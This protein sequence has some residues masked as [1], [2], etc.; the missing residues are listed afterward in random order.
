MVILVPAALVY[1]NPVLV[2]QPALL[3]FPTINST[4]PPVLVFKTNTIIMVLG[5]LAALLIVRAALLQ[6]VLSVLVTSL[7]P[8]IPVV[9][10]LDSSNLIPLVCLVSSTAKSVPLKPL[11]V[12]V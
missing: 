10:T 6:N 7:H 5:V 4:V 9:A 11:A 1:A 8:I 2:Q 3:V 12:N